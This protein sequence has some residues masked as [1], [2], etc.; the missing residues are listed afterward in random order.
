[1]SNPKIQ[2][3]ADVSGVQSALQKLQDTSE[4][5]NKTLTSGTVGIDTKQA[6][7]DLAELEESAKNLTTLLEKASKSGEALSSVEFKS[8]S[9]SLKSAS[10]SAETLDQVLNAVGQSSGMSRTVKGAKDT[11]DSLQ[12][13]SRAHEILTRE[14]V[15]Y[16]RIQVE[17]AKKSYDNWRQSGARGTS[18]I[19]GQEFD[20]WVGGGYKAFSIN[21]GESEN[22]RRSI[23]NS[24]GLNQGGGAASGNRGNVISFA[25]RMVGRGGMGIAQT[26]IPFSNSL[27]AGIMRQGATEGMA[28]EGGLLSGGG[29]GRLAMGTGIGALAMGGIGL[30]MGIKGGYDKGGTEAIEVTDLKHSLGDVNGDFEMLRGSIRH[31]SEGMGLTYN[32]SAK[33]A[34]SFAR[35]AGNI[36]GMEIGKSVGTATGFGRGYGVAPEATSQFMATMMHLGVSSSDQDNRKLAVMI[37]DSVHKGGTSTKMDEVLT[38]VSQYTTRQAQSSFS[39]PDAGAFTALLSSMTGLSFSGVKGDPTN[40]AATLSQVD[41][42]LRQGGAHGEASQNFTLGMYQRKMEGFTALDVGYMNDQGALGNVGGAF[43]TDSAAYKAADPARQA[44]MRKWVAGWEK[45]GSKSNLDMQMEALREQSGGDNMTLHQ[46]M[47]THFGL[48]DTQ[49]DVFKLAYEKK[50]SVSGLY[51]QLNG[52]GV[53]TSKMNMNSVAT[54]AQ[55]AG[56]SGKDISKQAKRLRGLTGDG[57]LSELDNI[58]LNRS[59]KAGGEDFKRAVLQL[60]SMHDV[61][62][63]DGTDEREQQVKLANA[64]QELATKLMPLVQSI[65]GGIVEIVRSLT[66]LTGGSSFVRAYDAEQLAKKNAPHEKTLKE[67]EADDKQRAF[68]YTGASA[69]ASSFE[70]VLRDKNANEA[71]RKYAFDELAKSRKIMADNAPVDSLDSSNP[72]SPRNKRNNNPGNLMY[73]GQKGATGKDADGFAIFPDAKTGSAAMD[74][75]LKSYGKD[76]RDTVESII[77]KWSPAN[78]KGNSRESTDA[79]IKNI[80]GKMGV[81]PGDHLGMDDPKVRARLAGLMAGH[82]GAASAFDGGYMNTNLADAGASDALYGAKFPAGSNSQVAPGGTFRLLADDLNINIHGEGGQRRETL[83]MN[84]SFNGTVAGLGR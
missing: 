12:R 63:D 32:E 43:G 37:G 68:N 3:S 48:G 35:T 41:A 34:R 58:E 60:T 65:Q 62:K 69:R 20:D 15:K 22:H 24:V 21:P 26:A 59:E 31:F 54:L 33:L 1:M 49:A 78:G 74:A 52:Y 2:V 80:S 64:M 44:Q 16:S 25:A 53:D 9:D 10:E 79:Y 75:Q 28:T 5:I 4:R 19:K 61:T 77:N 51:D 27:G 17:G 70:G 40:S 66:S 18:R 11:A 8:V 71:T 45:G 72:N 81:K 82:E 57:A 83:A 38:A 23:L 84:T 56:G 39:A 47:K 29:M 50:G 7:S 36:D 67:R 73:A 13:A 30:A 42:S 76:G 46:S 6:K 55:M 14:G